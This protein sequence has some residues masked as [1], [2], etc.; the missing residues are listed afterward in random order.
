MNQMPVARTKILILNKR[1]TMKIKILLMIFLMKV[2]ILMTGKLPVANGRKEESQK[3]QRIL[4]ILICNS[5][6]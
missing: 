4:R 5:I 6:P 1:K 2:I 3:L